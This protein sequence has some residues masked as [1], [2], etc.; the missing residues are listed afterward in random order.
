MKQTFTIEI[1]KTDKEWSDE[2][3]AAE[4]KGAADSPYTIAE[5][6]DFARADTTPNHYAII[7]EKLLEIADWAFAKVQAERIRALADANDVDL[8]A[9][10][11]EVK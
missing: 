4:L 7:R 11:V 5:V 8:D 1:E 6:L 3:K 10:E 9:V 2:V